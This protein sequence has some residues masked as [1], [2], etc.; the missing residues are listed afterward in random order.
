[1]SLTLDQHVTLYLA[2]E[3][4]AGES[5]RRSS[6]RA[7][8]A[9]PAASERPTKSTVPQQ[10]QQL[11]CRVTETCIAASGANNI[12]RRQQL[13]QQCRP[14]QRVKATAL[15]GLNCCSSRPHPQLSW[16]A[17]QRSFIRFNNRFISKHSASSSCR[18][19]LGPAV[20]EC[21]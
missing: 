8:R 20:T 18:A 10:Q 1:M 15:L 21:Y 12:D 3:L 2:P 14:H 7:H 13:Q 17:Q 9:A 11:E 4:G 6:R 5:R 19:A 16:A